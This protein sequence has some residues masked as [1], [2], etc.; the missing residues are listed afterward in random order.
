MLQGKPGEE[1]ENEIM[2]LKMTY[3]TISKI[4]N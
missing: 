4:Q 1:G 3:Q 2:A